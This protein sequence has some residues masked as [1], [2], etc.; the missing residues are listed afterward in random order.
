MGTYSGGTPPIEIERA[1]PPMKSI[2][3]PGIYFRKSPGLLSSTLPNS[4]AET[5]LLM[6]AAKR[7]SLMAMAAASISFEL[8]TTNWSSFT[9]EPSGAGAGGS[10][11][12]ERLKSRRAI[13]RG[14]TVTRAVC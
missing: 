2:V 5:T 4:S 10:G 13:S 12:E 14:A 1:A 3:M 11:L 8:E 7:C 6:E 9:I